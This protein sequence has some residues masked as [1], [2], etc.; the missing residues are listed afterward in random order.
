MCDIKEVPV[1]VE[2]VITLINAC[3]DGHDEAYYKVIQ[4]LRDTE[5]EYLDGLPTPENIGSSFLYTD[6]DL[7]MPV[8][9]KG[10]NYYIIGDDCPVPSGAVYVEENGVKLLDVEKTRER[11]RKINMDV[12]K[13]IINEKGLN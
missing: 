9:W 6:T 7:F 13:Q 11:F 2:R 8:E 5:K 4:Y 3:Y 1:D 12:A 10:D